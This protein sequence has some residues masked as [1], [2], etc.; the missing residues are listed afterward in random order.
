VD[1]FCVML[2]RS[3]T[4]SAEQARQPVETAAT[5]SSA[6]KAVSHSLWGTKINLYRYW[7]WSRSNNF[8]QIQ[9]QDYVQKNG[10]GSQDKT[11]ANLNNQN[12]IKRRYYTDI[13]KKYS[14]MEN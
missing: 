8:K 9:F 13:Q 4:L 2:T 14:F 7:Y 11:E 10:N 5:D 12:F 3:D 1:A 6:F